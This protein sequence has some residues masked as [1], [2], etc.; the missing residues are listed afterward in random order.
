IKGRILSI[1]GDTRSTA[2]NVSFI[3][4]SDVLIH[5]ATFEDKAKKI[6]HKYFHSTTTEAAQLAKEVHVKKLILTHIA[7]LYNHEY[8]PH[9]LQ[10]VQAIFLNTQIAK[11]FFRF[12]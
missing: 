6:A 3:K 1:L 12:T 7:S 4:G 11:D 9:I 5:E 2:K 10:E 8:L